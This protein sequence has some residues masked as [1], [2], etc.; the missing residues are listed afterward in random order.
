MMDMLANAMVVII[1]QHIWVSNQHIVYLKLTQ[2]YISM[3]LPG[4]QNIIRLLNGNLK[5]NYFQY[6]NPIKSLKVGGNKR[7]TFSNI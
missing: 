2:C 6:T 7:K 4:N 3:Y 1:L 5:E